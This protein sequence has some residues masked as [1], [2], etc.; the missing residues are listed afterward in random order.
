MGFE[1]ASLSRIEF[2]IFQLKDGSKALMKALIAFIIS[3]EL[4]TLRFSN[5]ISNSIPR[6]RNI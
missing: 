1:K 5:F 4:A 6:L 2:L 3:P